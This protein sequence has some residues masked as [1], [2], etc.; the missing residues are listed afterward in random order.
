MTFKQTTA[1]CTI[2]AAFSAAGCSQE[3]STAQAQDAPFEDPHSER[4]AHAPAGVETVSGTVVETMNAATY[5]YVRVDTGGKEI[6]AAASRFDVA[7]GDRVTVPLETPMQGFHSATLDRDFDL[8]YFASRI[9]AEGQEIGPS[10][11]PGHGK[12]AAPSKPSGQPV[13]PAAGGVT[14]AD[15]WADRAK[16]AGRTVTVRGRV[17]KFNGGIMGHNWLHIQDGTGDESTGTHDLTIT[18]DDSVS[19]GPIVTVTGVVA[20]DQDFGFGYS[21]KVMLTEATITPG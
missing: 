9:V 6:W 14:V 3:T 1:L 20:V 10:M 11:P 16:L 8:I 18:T 7:V 19:V 5:T 15:V 21:Y 2:L 12:P 4:A 13:K 17:V